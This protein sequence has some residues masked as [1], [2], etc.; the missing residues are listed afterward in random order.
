MELKRQK[1]EEAKKIEDARIASEE[2]KQRLISEKDELAKKLASITEKKEASEAIEKEYLLNYGIG[3]TSFN[4]LQSS[5]VLLIVVVVI[6][7]ILAIWFTRFP[8]M[9]EYIKYSIEVTNMFGRE[10][11]PVIYGLT[12]ASGSSIMAPKP[13]IEDNLTVMCWILYPNHPKPNP[14]TC[15]VPS[16]EFD[17]NKLTI[18]KGKPSKESS[19]DVWELY[20]NTDSIVFKFYPHDKN[21]V[22]SK[23]AIILNSNDYMK[24]LAVEDLTPKE[25]PKIGTWNSVTFSVNQKDASL[26]INGKVVAYTKLPKDSR[27]FSE[28]CRYVQIGEQQQCTA[29]DVVAPANVA[30]NAPEDLIKTVLNSDP[31][32]KY[33]VSV[34]EV[35]AYIKSVSIT[36]N[37][38]S[39]T[40]ISVINKYGGGLFPV[41]TL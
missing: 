24:H 27:I 17:K 40:M 13:Y 28:K 33:A 31:K 8:K 14:K 37:N 18:M 11:H 41:A 39:P 10:T 25:L 32:T 30:V 4:L 15:K 35:V 6:L 12:S 16:G 5:I 26:I 38:V 21:N 19:D 22:L 7:A 20:S 34:S 2:E 36:N 3:K 9:L 29:A 1:E 23:N